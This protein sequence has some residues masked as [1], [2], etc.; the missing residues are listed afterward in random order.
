MR[1]DALI[2]DVDGTLAETEEL[3]RAAFNA[4]FK[5][6]SL[7]WNWDRALYASLLKTAGGKE[8]IR[9]YIAAHLRTPRTSDLDVLV[10]VLHRRKTS[11]YTQMLAD[12]SLDL[13]P[14]VREVIEGARVEGLRLAIA[15]TTSRPNVDCLL[16]TT[17][18]ASGTCYFE[19]IA[20]GDAVARKKPSPEIYLH[21]LRVLNL[22]GAACLAL[23][24]S[25]LGLRAARLAEIPAL[26]TFS[27]YTRGE[28][29]TGAAA[30]VSALTDLVTPN[31]DRDARMTPSPHELF[32]ALREVHARPLPPIPTPGAR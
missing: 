4:A 1:L 21:V 31:C 14:G 17:F 15:T 29:F 5:D 27:N 26:I 16:R 9:H 8:R 3:H 13:R 10:E 7:D 6:A 25:Q 20:A 24:D 12:G 28:D 30:A 18:G 23:E 19:T 11:L 2:F 22:R 32:A